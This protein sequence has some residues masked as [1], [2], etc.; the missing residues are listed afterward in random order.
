[1]TQV[2]G[3]LKANFQFSTRSFFSF[4]IN[5]SSFFC[6]RHL[7]EYLYAVFL[8]LCYKSNSA[9]LGRLSGRSKNVPAYCRKFQGAKLMF[10]SEGRAC[11]AGA[12]KFLMIYPDRG[13]C[14]LKSGND[15]LI[16]GQIVLFPSSSNTECNLCIFKK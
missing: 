10:Y 5:L 1:M 9:S 16:H 7:T 14:L 2:C 11:V 3:T 15:L 4:D 8:S 12:H 6:D 13:K